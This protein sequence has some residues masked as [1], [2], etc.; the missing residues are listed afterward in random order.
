[1]CYE[2]H[3]HTH[4][5]CMALKTV[6]SICRTKLSERYAEDITM[7]KAQIANGGSLSMKLNILVHV[8]TQLSS[9]TRLHCSWTMSWDSSVTVYGL[10][11]WSLFPVRMKDFSLHL[12]WCLSSLPLS[13]HPMFFPG[14]KA[15]GRAKLTTPLHRMRGALISPSFYSFMVWCLDTGEHFYH[16]WMKR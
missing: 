4:T 10:H 16:S 6:F 13:G 7:R 1:M 14:G 8:S 9:V 11:C 2:G 3:T 5:S 15:A 12:P